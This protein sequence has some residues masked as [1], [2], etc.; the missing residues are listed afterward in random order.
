MS[1][2]RSSRLRTWAKMEDFDASLGGGC[3]GRWAAE[4]KTLHAQFK[5]RKTRFR[6]RL[7]RHFFLE[8]VK[9]THTHHVFGFWHHPD[10]GDQDVPAEVRGTATL[11]GDGACGT[12][13]SSAWDCRCCTCCGDG[14][15]AGVARAE[16][17]ELPA[18]EHTDPNAELDRG[19]RHLSV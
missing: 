10:V 6:V 3:Q 5:A 12:P 18:E 17:A 19:L 16:A 11:H 7:G 13:Q 9:N 15:A 14:A 2:H 1:L 8:K 4:V